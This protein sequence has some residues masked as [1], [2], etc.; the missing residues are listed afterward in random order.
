LA[1]S[2]LLASSCA[3]VCAKRLGRGVEVQ[4]QRIAFAAGAGERYREFVH[5]RQR[6]HFRALFHRQ[7]FRQRGEFGI[8][9][10]QGLVLAADRI[11][12]HELANGEDQ[13]QEHQHHQQ[14]AERIDEAGPEVDAAPAPCRKRAH[15]SARDALAIHRRGDGA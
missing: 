14:R 9:L 12:Q 1:T 5:L 4:A 3:W 15:A 6:L 7:R 13:Q 10:R 11:G 8:E 2:L